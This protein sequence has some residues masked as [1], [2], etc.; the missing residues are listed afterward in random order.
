MH[1]SERL[2]TLI[3]A[4][5]QWPWADTWATLKQRFKEDRLGVTAGSLTFT[6]TIAIVPL[7]T[8][9]LALFS[10]FPM[11]GKFRKALETNFL[12][13]LMPDIIAKEV[14][15]MLT[16]FAGKA[17]HLSG[18]SLLMLALTAMSLMLTMDRTLNGIWRVERIRPM[19]Q[20]VLVYWAVLTLG[21]LLL[22]VSLSASSWLLSASKG[23]V[24]A[25][26]AG[27]SLVLLVLVSMMQIMGFAALFRYVPNTSVKWRH[28]LAGGLFTAAGLELAQR[29]L[30]VYLTKAAVYTN[31]YGAFAALPIFL[32]WMYLSWLMILLGAVVA[33]YAP[34]LMA[35]TT[36]WTQLPGYQF[37]MALD[38]LRHLHKV[39]HQPKAGLTADNLA[40]HLRS[41]TL[42]MAPVL[43]ALIGLGWVAELN[44]QGQD[45]GN[46]EGARLVLLCMPSKTKVVPL[47]NALL[48]HQ[49]APGVQTIWQTAG[50][51]DMTL[52]E[53]LLT[54]LAENEN[55]V[56]LKADEA[57]S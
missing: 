50:F 15:V 37:A 32:V 7:L 20:R 43:D 34:V 10:A 27:M 29:G 28:A 4:A 24:D 49:A 8:M 53:A 56:I 30:G 16:K 3:T 42:Q 14:L 23:W 57:R 12:H 9:M 44:E 22:G 5:Q 38:V 48:L 54:P 45:S 17:S 46:D 11:F 1:A 25:V 6:T 52:S 39:Q 40:Q 2:H 19:A 47:V 33:A 41:N 36:R 31:V 26:P 51:S 35:H 18:I 55:A 13:D 21:P